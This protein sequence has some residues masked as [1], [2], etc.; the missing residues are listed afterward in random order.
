MLLL[1][2]PNT[3]IQRTAASV[4]TYGPLLHESAISFKALY[5][6]GHQYPY[7]LGIP[8]SN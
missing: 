5:T 7:W 3:A 4:A 6:Y 8:Q 1:P 2:L